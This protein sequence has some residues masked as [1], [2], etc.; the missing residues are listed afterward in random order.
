M[1]QFDKLYESFRPLIEQ[2]LIPPPDGVVPD[3]NG[4]GGVT[5]Q[6]PEGEPAPAPAQAGPKP[7]SVGFAIITQLILD[8]LR[9]KQPNNLADKK[10]S[11]NK[12]RTPEE[13]WK[14]IEIIK[15]NLPLDIQQKLE[16]DVGGAE[17][18]ADR[19]LDSL[20]IVDMANLGLKA[21]FFLPKLEEEDGAEYSDLSK[22]TKVDTANA[23]Q[24]FE[25]L[26]NF[27]STR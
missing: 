14:Y 11:D 5:G 18:E 20:N 15:R 4:V 22:V 7:S 25:E 27:L 23:E 19:D 12:A 26:R 6:P 13:A 17:G 8:A 10:Y 24:I 1:R 16:G 2:D 9:V 21:L 3:V